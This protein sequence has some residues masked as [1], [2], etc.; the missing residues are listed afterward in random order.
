MSIL[1]DTERLFEEF[2]VAADSAKQHLEEMVSNINGGKAPSKEL[3]NE[4]SAT[5][6]LTHSHCCTADEVSKLLSL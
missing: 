5:I 2:N 3:L 6:K 4:Y 1:Q